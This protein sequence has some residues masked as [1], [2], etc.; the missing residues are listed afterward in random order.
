MMFIKCL[1]V[2]DC[3]MVANLTIAAITSGIFQTAAF[4]FI[5][6]VH[7]FGEATAAQ[8]VFGA[9]VDAFSSVQASMFTLMKMLNGNF[10][11]QQMRAVSP[12]FAVVF[13]FYF[14]IVHWLLLLNIFLAL[15][16]GQFFEQQ[17]I[18]MMMGKARNQSWNDG[19][20]SVILRTLS[21]QW[22]HVYRK[23]AAALAALKEQMKHEKADFYVPDEVE[24][25]WGLGWPVPASVID[26]LHGWLD[27]EMKRIA[28]KPKK[29]KK[30]T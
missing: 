29:E 22:V 3:S 8:M 4:I 1:E 30:L 7:I 24:Y 2:F 9:E 16:K 20:Y 14:L 25:T 11:F 5:F 13:L 17:V 26:F 10:M 12:L 19:L 23:K 27:P 6:V 18:L 15:V 28:S 21:E